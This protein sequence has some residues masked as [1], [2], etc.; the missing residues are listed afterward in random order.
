MVIFCS[1]ICSKRTKEQFWLGKNRLG[2]M[3]KDIRSKIRRQQKKKRKTSKKAEA[4]S[5]DRE[6]RPRSGKQS[7]PGASDYFDES[8]SEL[9]NG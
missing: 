9:S 3:L 4:E 1:N 2:T 8:E 6:L 7:R 5:S